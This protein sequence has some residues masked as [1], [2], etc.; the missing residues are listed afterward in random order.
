MAV[1]DDLERRLSQHKLADRRV[2]D[3]L[4]GLLHPFDI[5]SGPPC[6][7][8]RTALFESLDK[9]IKP[10]IVDQMARGITELG[11]QGLAWRS[12]STSR[13]RRHR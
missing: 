1:V 3:H 6:S 8:L 13:V 2:L 5:V 9:P 11:E 7:K 12:Q 4:L 10:G